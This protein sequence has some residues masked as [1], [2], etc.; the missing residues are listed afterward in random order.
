MKEK[1][2]GFFNLQKEIHDY[3]G[4]KE[5]WSVF[6]MEDY[7]SVW[8]SIPDKQQDVDVVIIGVDKLEDYEKTIYFTDEKES[9][10]ELIAHN[11]NWEKAGMGDKCYSYEI[12]HQ[13]FLPTPIYPQHDYTMILVDTHTDGNK[14]FMVLDN[15]KKLSKSIIRKQKLEE[16]DG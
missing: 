7:T 1:I 10:V 14:Y 5:D 2:K 16:L 11:W 9:S 6:S 13:R 15:E 8:W 3:F 12:Y 4:Y